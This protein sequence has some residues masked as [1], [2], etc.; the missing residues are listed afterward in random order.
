ML[1]LLRFHPSRRD[2]TQVA[3]L[4]PPPHSLSTS[5]RSVLG[6]SAGVQPSLRGRTNGSPDCMCW[7][8]YG[9]KTGGDDDAVVARI[10]RRAPFEQR[11]RSVAV[12]AECV[13]A[14]A[15]RTFGE[16]RLHLGFEC[17]RVGSPQLLIHGALGEY[18]GTDMCVTVC[19]G[20]GF[21]LA[22]HSGAGF[23]SSSLFTMSVEHNTG[24]PQF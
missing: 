2:T 3:S 4:P 8:A 20:G 19:V 7:H 15:A 12:A 6:I 10:A 22:G 16:H 21:G 23:G 9:L 11:L 13:A 18:I 1:P 17:C 5:R 14:E 24:R